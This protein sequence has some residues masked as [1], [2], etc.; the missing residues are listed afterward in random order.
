MDKKTPTEQTKNRI[1]KLLDKSFAEEILRKH[2][3]EHLDGFQ[4]L[5]SVELEAH[6]KHLGATSAV[7]V[8]EYRVK[9][10]D[11]Q[12]EQQSID[13]FAGAHSDGT[14]EE[15]YRKT[16]FLYEHGFG[17][18]K[19]RVTKPLFFSKEQMAFFYE[20]S[21][22]R[23]LF[24]FFT[25]DP[26]ADLGPS[27]TL[28]AGWIKKLHCFDTNKF[29]FDW[30]T[31]KISG[32]TPK[33]SKFIADFMD[34]DETQ[35]KLVKELTEEMNALENKFR[36]KMGNIVIY[37][38]Y[39]PENIIVFDLNSKD[40]EMIDFTDLAYGDPMMDLGTFLQQLD[41]MGH[42]FISREQINNYKTFFISAYFKKDFDKID[43]EYISRINLYQAWTALRTA[44]FLFYM[45]DAENPIDD[46]LQDSQG[47]LAVVKKEE[48]IINLH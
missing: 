2:L 6:K 33:P 38:D 5:E 47:Y 14:K 10:I 31:F 3:P 30:P 46:L 21:I 18:G 20:A 48:K 27:L 11:K 32:M 24:H 7:F 29:K 13:I 28:A 19:Y 17:K 37:G 15:A 4:E 45:N 43:I 26:K 22:G 9:Y 35:G 16:K 41:F 1:A 34:Q 25:Q 39:H 40:L 44:I 8:V 12:N 23:S 42:N 36:A